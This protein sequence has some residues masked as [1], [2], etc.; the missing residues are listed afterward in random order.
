[1]LRGLF[2]AAVAAADPARCLPAWL[3]DPPSGRTMVVGAGKAAAAMA[4]AVEDHWRGDPAQL[5]GRAGLRCVTPDYLPLVGP[6]PIEHLM[7]E[8]FAPLRRD[9]RA[10]I[11][12]PGSYWPGLF[13]HGGHGSR[14]L[15]HAPLC[16]TLLAD[17][18]EGRPRPLAQEL[19][20][21]LN[22]ARFLI[23]ALKRGKR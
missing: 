12:C 10:D 3:P 6:A 18:I 19:V 7:L 1:V 9:A 15:S 11:P 21:A 16:A 2:D 22:P 14:G 20:I 4:R 23:R 13:I 17:L 8:T 5:S